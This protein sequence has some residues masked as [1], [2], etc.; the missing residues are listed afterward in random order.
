M[1]THAVSTKCRWVGL[2]L[3]LLL[4]LP[5]LAAADP[6]VEVGLADAQRDA[7]AKGRMI[8][9]F[10]PAAEAGGEELPEPRFMVRPGVDAIQV[11]GVDV[12]GSTPDQPVV[13]DT[14]TFGYPIASLYNLPAGEYRVQAVLHRYE[15]FHRADGHTVELPMDRGEGQHWNLAPGNLYSIPRTIR[16]DPLAAE[17]IR[18]ELD[19]VIPRIEPPPTPNG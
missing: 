11:F 10:A 17:P 9:L 8:V 13:I 14:T 19:E 3:F 16:F 1:M 12:D 4:A 5:I 7:T 15:T 18:V 2:A 6:R